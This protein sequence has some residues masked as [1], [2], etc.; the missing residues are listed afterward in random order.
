MFRAPASEC[1]ETDLHV[2]SLDQQRGSK[3][4]HQVPQL[5]R[6]NAPVFAANPVK[7]SSDNREAAKTSTRVGAVATVAFLASPYIGAKQILQDW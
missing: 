1:Q 3:T 7:S 6:G 4:L 5:L 2:G